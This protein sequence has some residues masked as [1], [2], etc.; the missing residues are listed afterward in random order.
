MQT[1]Q[2][3][4]KTV[5]SFPLGVCPW[6]LATNTGGLRKTNKA[7]ILHRLEKDVATF[8]RNNHI[9][10][11]A[12]ILD[13][14]AMIQKTKVLNMTFSQLAVQLFKSIINTSPKSNRTDVVFDV[15][16]NNSIKDAERIRKSKGV[17]R[18]QSIRGDQPIKQWGSF[19]SCSFNKTALVHEWMKSSYTSQLEEHVIFATLLDKCY[20]SQ[21]EVRKSFLNCTTPKKKQIR[22]LYFMQNKYVN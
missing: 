12:N 7:A 4:L 1:R 17:L 21:T 13:G 9:I 19:L 16:Q 14:M 5:F 15:Y 3:D 18:F 10:N 6:S 2:I 20:N 11:C 8:S 22:V